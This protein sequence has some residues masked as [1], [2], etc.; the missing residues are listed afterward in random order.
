MEE[1]K[2]ALE[3][4][5]SRRNKEDSHLPYGCHKANNLAKVPVLP[6]T[7]HEK[8]QLQ[9]LIPQNG[10]QIELSVEGNRFNL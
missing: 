3:P 8:M 5:I 10:Q 2:G 1:L 6:I 7:C 4:S 9:M